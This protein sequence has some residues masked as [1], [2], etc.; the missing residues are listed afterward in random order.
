[1]AEH[2]D[3]LIRNTTIVDGT[4]RPA[5][6]GN[7]AITGDRIT[8]VGDVQGAAARV[9]DGSGLV[10]SPGFVDIH[11]HADTSILQYPLAENLAM[12][13]V[14][15]FV[16]GNCGFS[17]APILAQASF[18]PVRRI[19][20]V[21]QALDWRTFAQWLAKVEAERPAP[22]YVPMVGHNTIRWA[23]M[24]DDFRRKATAAEIS[25]MKSLVTEAMESGAFGLSS[26]V[27]AAW[28]GHFAH[29][30]EIIELVKVARQFDGLYTPH[31]RHHQNQWPAS[32][33]HE[34]GYGVFHAPAGEIVTGRY[35][36]L[37]EAVEISRLAGGVRLHIAH[38][39]PAYII[40][41]PHPAFLD[42]AAARATLVDIVDKAKNDGLDVT[43]NVV[44]WRQSIG[45]QVPIVET[46][47]ASRA[48]LPEW[49]RSLTREQFVAGLKAPSFRKR[50]K[51][52]VYSGKFKFG[53]LHPLTDPYWMDCYQVLRCRNKEYEGRTIGEIARR[54]Q[55]QHIIAAVYDEALAVVF[56]VLL[57]DPEATW[58]LIND[59]RVQGA[60]SIFMQHPDGMPSSD[61][62]A[63]PATP[64][65]SSSIYGF[66]IPP[67]A[68][69][70]FPHFLRTVVREQG[71]LTLVD[72]GVL[73]PGACADV[74]VFDAAT[75][76]EANDLLNPTRP[77]AGIVHVLVN[78]EMIYEQGKHTGRRPGRV[79]RRT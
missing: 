27:D 8:R 29:V 79:L 52:V 22:N 31:T 55:P 74:V 73:A 48:L 38:L 59:K 43:F 32:H 17:M 28:A 25:A 69:G 37:L 77:P 36:G 3:V 56:D 7:V 26:G 15:T 71:I 6:T 41:Q 68:Y 35:H 51:D 78:G 44:A 11:T 57:D 65:G 54:R 21:D 75:I 60:L 16:G 30:D 14:T 4:G 9:I 50:V 72:R 63:M 42:E 70:L 39:T 58:A 67:I 62:Q 19:W 5:Y 46:F 66:G 34:F 76:G 12:Q 24:G 20:A 23:V 49:F 13:G 2:F 47:F 33:P 40:P 61:V 45:A 18:E 10:T 53:M 1:M 64:A